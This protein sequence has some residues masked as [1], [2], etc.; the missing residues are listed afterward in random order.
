MGRNRGRPGADD[1]GVADA[2]RRPLPDIAHGEHPH[3]LIDA[4]QQ[5]IDEQ[6]LR[7]VETEPRGEIRMAIE[8]Q[9][10][11][12]PPRSNHTAGGGG[13]VPGERTKPA[14]AFPSTPLLSN[15]LCG[16]T[17]HLRGFTMA[18]F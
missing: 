2:G 3:R 5:F 9:R 7:Q 1:G 13:A 12:P 10:L 14:A 8:F 6:R 15:F 17:S 18:Q 4:A 16:W 11:V